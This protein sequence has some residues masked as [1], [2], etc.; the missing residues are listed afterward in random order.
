MT[1]RNNF[2]IDDH[3]WVSAE[4]TVDDVCHISLGYD[5][6]S[7]ATIGSFKVNRND[8]R[9][10][11]DNR[12]IDFVQNKFILWDKHLEEYRETVVTAHDDEE[13]E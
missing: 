10:N 3:L 1:Y 13:E 11:I 12:V 8:K 2:L 9:V 6:E 7:Q 5:W 4:T